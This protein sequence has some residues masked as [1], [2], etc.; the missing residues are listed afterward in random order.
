MKKIIGFIVLILITAAVITM[1]A[2]PSEVMAKPD[3][4]K[5]G[6][7]DIWCDWIDGW[8]NWQDW[9]DW[10]DWEDTLDEATDYLVLVAQ[11]DGSYIAY[12]DIAFV[13]GNNYVMVK[14]K[15]AATALG[16]TYR[17]ISGNKNKK[18]LTLTLG[19]DSNLYTRNS[20]TYYFLDYNVQTQQTSKTKLYAQYKQMVYEKY[21]AVHCASLS[22]LVNYQYYDTSAVSDYLK[23]GYRGVVVYS[24]YAAITKLPPIT[25]IVN[26]SGYIAINNPG[27]GQNNNQNNNNQNNNTGTIY[28]TVKPVNVTDSTNVN[29]KNVEAS[30]T[31]IDTSSTQILDLSEVLAAFQANGLPY[32]GLYGSGNCDT[33]VT[34]QGY[35]RN[36]SFVGE[37]KTTGGEF[38]FSF[39]SA[40]RVTVIGTAK[41]LVMDF[42]PV[43]PVLVNANARLPFNTLSWLYQADGYARIYYVLGD[44]IRFYTENSAAPYKVF[45]KFLSVI[46]YANPDAADAYQRICVV[47]KFNTS[48][49]SSGNCFINIQKTNLGTINNSLV[50]FTNT[51][52]A[53]LAT[54]YEAKLLSMIS[55]LG[56]TGLN[57]YF[58]S[59][60]WNRQLIMKLPDNTVNTAYTYITVDPSYLN[61]DYFFDYYMTLH[62]MVHF[63]EATKP[64]YGMNFPAWTD[65]SA[66]N[67]AEK[68]LDALSVIHKDSYGND[69]IDNMYATDFSFLSQDNRN[70]FESY[71]LNTTGW[72]ATVIGYHFT[73]FLQDLYGSDVVYKINQK[74]L[75][76]N[77]P[78]GSA[79]NAAYDKIFL[80]CIKSATSQNV[81]QLF[82]EQ[83]VQ[84]SWD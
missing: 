71:Y 56:R 45:R 14:A 75:A 61:L 70:N 17:T 78:A 29:F 13:T 76:A 50:V 4:N 54:D 7:D 48:E 32:T 46:N 65:G 28:V 22:T 53:V 60:N 38:V 1:I 5:A 11:S 15:P 68:T 30:Y 77:I 24:R 18:G 33:K 57:T 21:N 72:N 42:T 81:F 35:D 16:M 58:G 62:E 39:P 26:F 69:Y 31:V 3:K 2:P 37:M 82:I 83:H 63:Y 64:Y 52:N 73:D 6:N 79:R 12:D 40:V 34:L 66:T 80:D 74:I 25:S 19:Q 10:W 44:N 9:E 47:L 36:G 55:T 51:G 67:L 23:L 20:T 41:N 43:M 59:A 84:K 49:M 27:N 8:Q